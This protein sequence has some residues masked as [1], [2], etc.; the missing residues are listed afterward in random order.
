MYLL[1]PPTR[2]FSGP[3]WTR[4]KKNKKDKFS[5]LKMNGHVVVNQKKTL[6]DHDRYQQIAELC[7]ENVLLNPFARNDIYI[8]ISFVLFPNSVKCAPTK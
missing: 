8:Y 2:S 7:G 4:A 1:R 6:P 5:A 3:K